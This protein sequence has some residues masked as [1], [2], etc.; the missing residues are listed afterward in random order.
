MT[1][2]RLWLMP[3]L[4]W[5]ALLLLLALTVGSAFLPLGIG[6]TIVN[7]AIAG[8]KA[9]LVVVF[10]MELSR[11]STLIR[12]A[13]AAGAFWLSFLFVLSAGDYLTRL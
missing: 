5:L 8:M 9:A 13:A 6:N 10:F 3:S 1:A 12:I 2:W 7:M 11:S 4:I